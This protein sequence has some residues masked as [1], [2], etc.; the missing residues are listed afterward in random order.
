M[1]DV[2]SYRWYAH[3]VLI[4]PASSFFSIW[5]RP[6]I[7]TCISTKNDSRFLNTTSLSHKRSPRKE[8]KQFEQK[9]I[10]IHHRK[11]SPSSSKATRS[12]KFIGSSWRS[13][14]SKNLVDPT[15]QPRK[16]QC[17]MMME[18]ANT[19]I[20]SRN[21]LHDLGEFPSL[22]K[23]ILFHSLQLP[24]I[25]KKIF[26]YPYVGGTVHQ[27][28]F[29]KLYIRLYPVLR[30]QMPP[31]VFICKTKERKRET[32][33]RRVVARTQFLQVAEAAEAVLQLEDG[34]G[35]PNKAA[36]AVMAV[37]RIW[38]MGVTNNGNLIG[39][40]P[41]SW[42][43]HSVIVIQWPETAVFGMRHPK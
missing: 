42:D 21:Q 23:A 40:S 9:N 7:G 37:Q 31:V 27:Q 32:T 6:K 22:L 11:H 16:W 13:L 18:A 39:I 33:R 2:L 1:F 28:N 34:I 24:P 8:H 4:H 26:S 12:P 15:R 19:K 5:C 29:L 25:F 35:S 14:E 41:K 3:V 17:G 20:A 10:R 43:L 30:L 36:E 38:I